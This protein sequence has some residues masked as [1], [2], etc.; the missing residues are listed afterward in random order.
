M[1]LT[2]F[3]VFGVTSNESSMSLW[4]Q[5]RDYEL[6]FHNIATNLERDVCTDM[7]DCFSSVTNAY[8]NKEIVDI[9]ICH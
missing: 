6:E 1:L 5:L 7:C 8:I 3:K 4:R 9:L 2:K